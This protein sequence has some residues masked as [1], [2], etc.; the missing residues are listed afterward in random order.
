MLLRSGD[1][2]LREHLAALQRADDPFVWPE[3]EFWPLALEVEAVFERLGLLAAGL[4]A[5]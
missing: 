3:R 1:P 2:L 5:A 4:L